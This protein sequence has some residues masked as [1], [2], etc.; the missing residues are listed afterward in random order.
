MPGS[1]R[2]MIPLIINEQGMSALWRGTMPHVYKQWMQIF[3]K[4]AFYDRI[5]HASMPYSPSKY[6]TMDYFIRA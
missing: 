4:V 3:W 1:T 5:K 6:S 2:S